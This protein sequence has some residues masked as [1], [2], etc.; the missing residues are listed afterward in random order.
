MSSPKGGHSKSA[1]TLRHSHYGG[2]LAGDEGN[3]EFEM[4]DVI[5]VVG[6][7]N[8]KLPS[9]QSSQSAS[10][11]NLHGSTRGPEYDDPMLASRKSKYE[12]QTMAEIRLQARKNGYRAM[13]VQMKKLRETERRYYRDS[14]LKSGNSR[15]KSRKRMKDYIDAH[16]DRLMSKE[17]RSFATIAK[18]AILA[19]AN[20][21]DG[22]DDDETTLSNGDSTLA[23]SLAGQHSLTSMASVVSMMSMGQHTPTN[24]IIAKAMDRFNKR[25]EAYERKQQKTALV[26]S[27]LLAKLHDKKMKPIRAKQERRRLKALQTWLAWV[28][29]QKSANLLKE[30][31]EARKVFLEKLE[32]Q[33]KM[34]TK[35]QT[36]LARARTKKLWAKYMKFYS[37]VFRSRWMFQ[38]AIRTWRK[39]KSANIV[40]Q[41]LLE[42][43]DRN[44][45]NL[46]VTKFLTKVRKVQRFIKNFL[47]CHMQ[48]LQ[49]LGEM[50]DEVE[51]KFAK[52]LENRMK[53]A[54]MMKPLQVSRNF[55][56]DPL[57]VKAYNTTCELWQIMDRK[58]EALLQSER[59]KK[60]LPRSK[61]AALRIQKLTDSQKRDALSLVLKERRKWH[62]ENIAKMKEK[63]LHERKKRALHRYDVHDA[64]DV[65][66]LTSINAGVTKVKEESTHIFED[67]PM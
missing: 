12:R 28:T 22:I 32:K 2:R 1:A 20:R 40:K 56:I 60:H 3:S 9:M 35:L 31:Y 17:D 50:W 48:R 30:K 54:R 23:S 19:E 45:M 42:N 18:Q 37:V 4:P 61:M 65:L 36:S 41:F 26:R 27:A 55:K 24:V 10:N 15:K 34:A 33:N 53:D 58:M 67:I 38:M 13:K 57:A 47:H 7:T 62:I 6:G 44:P 39:K 52:R 43:K 29:F 64:T 46:M 8:S 14:A 49:M 59:E 11:S 63:I 21:L 51:D 66:N 25:K 5:Q 16:R